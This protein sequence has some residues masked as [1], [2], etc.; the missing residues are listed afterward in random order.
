MNFTDFR[1]SGSSSGIGCPRFFTALR[2][3]FGPG[4]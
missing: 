1:K 2:G 4:G 3:E